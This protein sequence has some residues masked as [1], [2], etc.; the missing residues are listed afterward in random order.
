MNF[1][2]EEITQIAGDEV[3]EDKIKDNPK[4]DWVDIV[5]IPERPDD[6][7]SS[8]FLAT[9]SE[10]EG[11]WNNPFDRRPTAAKV[12][13]DKG[14]HLGIESGTDTGGSEYLMVRDLDTLAEELY[15]HARN[16]S[17]PYIVG[18]TGSV[19]KTTTVAFL[20]HLI[21]T[22]G[23]DVTR[24]YSKRL[25]PLSVMCHYINRVE[26]ETPFIVME[27]S[28]Y[29]KDHVAQLSELIP[30]NISFLTNIYNTHINPGMF[31]NKQEIFESK[32][33]IKPKESA[34][35]VNNRVL[36]ELGLQMPEGWMG[37]DVDTSIEV[38]NEFLPPTLRTAEM[39]AVGNLMAN[40]LNL[41]PQ[42][43]Q[44]AFETFKPVENR[45][46]KCNYHGNSVFFHGET[47]GG[48]RLWSWF[49]TLNG[50][51]PWL[52]VEEIN[53]ADEDPHGFVNLLENIF[54]SDKTFV[55]DTPANRERLP[56]KARFVDRERFGQTLSDE[57][58]DYIVF[59]KALS[60]RQENFNPEEYL[61]KTW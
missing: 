59:H 21:R 11:D 29:L 14:W 60:T 18:V 15:K 53:F 50:E 1:F 25:T 55:L 35:Y 41:S 57:A 30:P 34:G 27:Y 46:I 61:N 23:S 37:F 48:S 26:K 20:E 19:G 56:V 8:L 16:E 51:L 17:N 52:L 4:Y 43:L 54:S 39:Y 44:R 58:N 7:E 22:S 6:I 12:A 45:I 47:S 32:V 40:K 38:S 49:E 33:R 36:K 5:N 31:K 13:F 10:G 24:F 3:I 42:L 2:K 28:T 9:H